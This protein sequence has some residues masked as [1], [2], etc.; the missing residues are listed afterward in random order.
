MDNFT[1]FNSSNHYGFSV[2]RHGGT[3]L[4]DYSNA[5][6]FKQAFNAAH[7]AGGSG[8]T[9]MYKDKLYNTNCADGKDYGKN[10]DKNAS[11][12]RHLI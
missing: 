10:A 2:S 9:F 1:G 7:H 11:A 8:H 5:G 12:L 4:G 6:S 3:S